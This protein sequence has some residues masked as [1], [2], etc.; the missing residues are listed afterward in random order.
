MNETQKASALALLFY[1]D[2]VSEQF[3]SLSKALSDKN[4]NINKESVFNT[5]S[6]FI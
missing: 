3:G 5:A 4:I 6:G 1:N 2:Y